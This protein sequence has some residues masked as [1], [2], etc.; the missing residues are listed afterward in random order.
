MISDPA[1]RGDDLVVYECTYTMWVPYKASKIVSPLQMYL[2]FLLSSS[3]DS[4]QNEELVTQ[5][6]TDAI[7]LIYV[8][9]YL[10]PPIGI[11]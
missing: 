9:T 8:S 4:I 7:G 1:H 6:Q 10:A 5:L 2:L 11:Y 3:P